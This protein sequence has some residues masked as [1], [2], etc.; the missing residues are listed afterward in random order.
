MVTHYAE[1]FGYIFGGSHLPRAGRP[2]APRRS[3]PAPQGRTARR[4]HCT[5]L[6]RVSSGHF[7]ASA[8]VAEGAPGGRTSSRTPPPLSIEPRAVEGGRFLARTLSAL[9][10]DESGE[11]EDFCGR[12]VRPR[13][14]QEPGQEQI[15]FRRNVRSEERRV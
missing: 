11:F 2:H 15:N 10:A 1:P 8:P 4:P 12:R 3:R 5:G 14:G 13:G 7:Q 6:S 9:L